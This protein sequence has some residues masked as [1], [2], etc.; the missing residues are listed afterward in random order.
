MRTFLT[1]AI[2]GLVL[3]APSAALAQNSTERTLQ[4]AFNENGTVDL[5][6]RNVTVRDILSEWS[7]Q[8]DCN[9]V[10]AEQLRGG[11][12]MLPLQFEGA[13][14]SDVLQSLLR[15]AAGYVLTPQRPG[16]ASA[17]NY[18]TIYILA[19]SNPVAGAYVP[20]STIPSTSMPT[21]GA[22]EDEIPPVS[23]MPSDFDEPAREAPQG[24][25]STNPFGSRT[26]A[27]SVYAPGST[28]PGTSP[29]S[30]P[31]NQPVA[32]GTAPPP[33]PLPPG[34]EQPT[35]PPGFSPSPLPPGTGVPIVPVPPPDQ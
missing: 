11:A 31:G 18:E 17:S 2:L 1:G 16:V 10:N 14:Q 7:K 5:A 23:P 25:P 8:C 27:P 24:P 6:A 30:S 15:Q 33:P 32:P 3:A 26:S 19:T 21:M 22:P 28:G 4:L 35:L 13:S 9:V 34:G 29:G 12:I 20:P